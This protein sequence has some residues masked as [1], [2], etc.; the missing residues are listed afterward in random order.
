LF[1]PYRA[2]GVCKF[3]QSHFH[4]LQEIIQAIAAFPAGYNSAFDSCLDFLF[5]SNRGA[6]QFIF[7]LKKAKNESIKACEPIHQFFL[8]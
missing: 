5:P 1:D 8:R 3:W 6:L 2:N 4:P 7:E